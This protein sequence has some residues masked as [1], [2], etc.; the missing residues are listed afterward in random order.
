VESLRSG[1]SSARFAERNSIQIVLQ[2]VQT[3]GRAGLDPSALTVCAKTSAERSCARIRAPL[4]S[5][6][7]VSLLLLVIKIVDQYDPC[8]DVCVWLCW[9]SSCFGSQLSK[10]ATD[11]GTR[12]DAARKSAG[13]MSFRIPWPRR[14]GCGR[15]LSSC[16]RR[17]VSVSE[18]ASCF[19]LTGG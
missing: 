3:Q 4:L 2:I 10:L 17:I 16:S 5:D 12:V 13:R 18:S 9:Q 15:G 7:Y 19:M 14:A 1:A 8:V 6:L 11:P